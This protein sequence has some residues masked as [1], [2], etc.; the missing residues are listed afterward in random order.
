MDQST[1]SPSS[2]SPSLPHSIET[3][4]LFT[5]TLFHSFLPVDWSFLEW[6][7]EG[8][9]Y[10]CGWIWRGEAKS[11]LPFSISSS[12]QATERITCIKVSCQVSQRHPILDHS[13][14]SPSYKRIQ[15]PP[16]PSSLRYSI[17][18]S[19]PSTGNV[20]WDRKG[21]LSLYTNHAI[22]LPLSVIR[23]Q[24]ISLHAVVPSVCSLSVGVPSSLLIHPLFTCIFPIGP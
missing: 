13:S 4:T 15:S 11:F 9:Q 7:R 23:M 14:V 16:P 24:M 18:S 2:A 6:E 20:T 1:I 10:W 19:L 8:R 17:P 22:H 5:C 3:S 12:S 21:R